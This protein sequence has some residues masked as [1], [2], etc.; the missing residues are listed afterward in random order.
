[1]RDQKMKKRLLFFSLMYLMFLQCLYA[2]DFNI[3]KISIS[4]DGFP[5]HEFVVELATTED[6][7]SLGLMFRKKLPQDRGMLFIY[8]SE[9]V[10]KMW[11]K[12]TFIPL[13]MLFLDKNGF[14]THLVKET[15]P[16][17][18]EIISSMGNVLGVLELLGGTSE[19]LGIRIGD[20]V[21]HVAFG[22]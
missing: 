2:A 21:E 1:M 13:D 16:L 4:R 10:V 18:L 14:I 19:K 17:S 5:K 3:S 15:R 6:E 8:K 11:M 12:N 7:R 22:S 20:R 9:R